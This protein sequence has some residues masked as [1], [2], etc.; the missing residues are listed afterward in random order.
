[1]TASYV[2]YHAV[3]MALSEKTRISGQ[4]G[5]RTKASIYMGNSFTPTVLLQNVW[6][7]L[8]SSLTNIYLAL[9]L[10]PFFSLPLTAGVVGYLSIYVA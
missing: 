3:G 2:M 1:M 7:L 9:Q 6:I 10:I 4:S 8:L 5:P